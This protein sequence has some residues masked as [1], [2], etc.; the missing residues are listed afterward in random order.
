MSLKLYYPVRWWCE[1]S[2]VDAGSGLGLGPVRGTDE[3]HVVLAVKMSH[4]KA[5]QS[6][7]VAL[8]S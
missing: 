7:V 8:V 4:M 6:R 1:S 3:E 5:Q 2:K